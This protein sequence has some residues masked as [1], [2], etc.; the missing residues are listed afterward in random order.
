MLVTGNRGGPW[1]KHTL[2]AKNERH[3]RKGMRYLQSVTVEQV[4]DV[5][6]SCAEESAGKLSRGSRES[7]VVSTG[8]S[9]ASPERLEFKVG[10]VIPRGRRT[11]ED[12]RRWNRL[13]ED[14]RESGVDGPWVEAVVPG[15]GWTP[16]LAVVIV[17]PTR[18][19]TSAN[20]WALAG[21]PRCRPSTG[22][23]EGS[24]I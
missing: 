5:V 14:G 8:W 11:T 2:Y 3:T 18:L 12:V 1:L 9:A 22:D 10:Y 23:A 15:G 13:P 6:E 4:V 19:T 24:V 7:G 16:P 21:I 17:L 20:I